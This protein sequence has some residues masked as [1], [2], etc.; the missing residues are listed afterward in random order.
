M[1]DFILLMHTGANSDPAAWEPYLKMLRESGRFQGGSAIGDGACVSK[2]GA[3]P[4]ITRHLSGYLKV[5]ANSLDDAKTL[6]AGNPVY[7]AGG[8][9]ELRHLPTS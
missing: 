7:E 3:P 4:G 2:S 9:V 6:L 8:V 1:E 5:K